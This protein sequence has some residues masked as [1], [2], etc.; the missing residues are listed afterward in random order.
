MRTRTLVAK[1]ALAL[2]VAQVI[3]NLLSFVSVPLLARALQS[4]RYGTWW[5]MGQIIGFGF[6]LVDFG[7]EGYISLAVARD[8]SRG[9]AFLGTTTALRLA[10]TV[11][12]LPAYEI[13]FRLLHLDAESRALGRVFWAAS[14]AT[15]LLN[16]SISV[17]RGHE[18]MG[19]MSF[20]RVSGEVIWTILM[21]GGI[22][23]GA[24]MIPLAWLAVLGA[25]IGLGV[26]AWVVWRLPLRPTAP[27]RALAKELLRG[28]APFFLY[29]GILA[30]QPSLEAVILSKLSSPE[31]VGW[32]AATGKLLGLLLVPAA[33][34]MGA[35][36]PTLAR[37]QGGDPQ[38]FRKAA[39][40]SLRVT[41]LMAA[42]LTV[43]TFAFA[44]VA[45]GIIYGSRSFGPVGANL[46]VMSGFIVPVFVN[47]TLGSV[48]LAS[49]RQVAWAI[50]KGVAVAVTTLAS[51]WVI[52]YIHQRT[53]NGG[54]GAAAMTVVSEVAITFVAFALLPRGLL[55]RRVLLDAGRAVAAA[56]AMAVVAALLRGAPVAVFVAVPLL[57][58]A[59]VARAVG[60]I[61]RE[62]LGIVRDVLRRK[63]TTPTAPA[64]SLFPQGVPGSGDAPPGHLD[65]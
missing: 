6:L 16:G 42:P 39:A 46:R 9:P 33:L 31:A 59:A 21:V 60:A 28:G 12:L 18:R 26:A 56:A 4:S 10:G 1:N 7:Q 41:L 51:F 49:G 19:W 62:D 11:A 57:T 30:V 23:L 15:C 52:P 29:G 50:A 65:R 17:I 54:L 53:G 3:T 27:D 13:I 35:L 47:I 40:E 44:D 25:V 43:A 58:F 34:L 64:E 24:G 63:L 48:L 8:R 22:L 5:L 32:Y 2:L 55:S 14:A 38:A 36:G 20:I 45:T 61:R 37:L